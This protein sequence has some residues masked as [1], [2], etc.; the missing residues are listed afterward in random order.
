MTTLSDY[1]N[2]MFSRL[3][4]ANLRNHNDNYNVLLE[5]FSNF[6]LHYKQGFLNFDDSGMFGKVVIFPKILYKKINDSKS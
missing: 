6:A 5:L 2:I 4:K 1:A 3:G